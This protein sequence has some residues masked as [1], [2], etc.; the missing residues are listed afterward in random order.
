MANPSNILGPLGIA[1]ELIS[2]GFLIGGIMSLNGSQISLSIP[3]ILIGAI[4]LTCEKY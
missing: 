3:G 2:I 1:V 4:L